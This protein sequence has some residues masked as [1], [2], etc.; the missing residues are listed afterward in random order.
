MSEYVPY[1]GCA[2]KCLETGLLVVLSQ[3]RRDL[4]HGGSPSTHRSGSAALSLVVGFDSSDSAETRHR[5]GYDV[6]RRT[7]HRDTEDFTWSRLANGRGSGATV[8]LAEIS[9]DVPRLAFRGSGPR[10]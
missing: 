7:R 8:S 10:G 2:S 5:D 6:E 3:P 9:V 1:P 4:S